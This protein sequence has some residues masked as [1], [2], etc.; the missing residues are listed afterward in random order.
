MVRPRATERVGITRV[1][2]AQQLTRLLLL[3]VEIG[4][5]G[6]NA[7]WIGREEDLLHG[8]LTSATQAERG[9]S[10]RPNEWT[11]GRG[12]FRGLDPS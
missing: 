4:M 2:G 8:R 10:S 3:L 1:D 9:A 5:F 12:P 11:G 7:G 6:K